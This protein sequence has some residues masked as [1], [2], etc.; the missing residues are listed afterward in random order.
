LSAGAE[1]KA[2][3]ESLGAGQIRP[4]DAH[5]HTGA[6][7]DGSTRTS[8]EHVRELEALDGQSV[9]FPFCVAGGYELENSRVVEECERHPDRLV[10]FA[11]LDPKISAARD[12]AAALT[13]GARGFKLHPR[14]EHFALDHPGVGE[15][16]GVAAAARVPVLIH[17]GTGVGTFGTAL[18]TL[19][20][21]HPEC[22]IILAHAGVS[23]LAWLWRV[24]PDHPNIYFDTAWLVA[25]DLLALF[26]LVPPGRILYGSDAPYMDVELLLAVALR[27]A[28]FSGF[29]DDAIS[30]VMGGQLETLLAGEPGIDAGPAVGP[31]EQALT[32][33][34]SRLVSLLSAAGG[35]M[36]GGGDPSRSLDL[37]LLAIVEDPT[38]G[39][40][41]RPPLAA[42][43]EESRSA[44][45]EA[46][47]ALVF[48]LT[49]AMTPGVG[50]EAVVG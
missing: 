38:A 22:P 16:F 24:V 19:A 34:E 23:D 21:D 41:G 2:E 39:E 45:P 9:I 42:L 49:L 36:L 46:V 33:T 29:S 13:A 18:T 14:A 44:S 28:R 17:A 50:E 32:P 30:L 26:A 20:K 43:I 6:D 8:E 7:I 47:R 40:G 3:L 27:C 4:F 37:A 31:S 11:R 10:P 1:I 15:L 12:A 35:C 5:A 48:A 25:A